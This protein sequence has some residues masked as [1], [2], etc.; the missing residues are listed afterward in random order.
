MSHPLNVAIIGLGGF[1]GAHHRTVRALELEGQCQ[2]ACVSSRS[3]P[4]D[5]TKDLD[6]EG[7]GVRL[8][9]DWK[10]MLDICGD[11]LDMVCVPTP[12]NMHAP[13]HRDCVD[14]GLPVFLEKPP[15]NDYAEL[16]SMLDVEQRAGKQTFVG[17]NF[18]CQKP[19]Q[20][21]K[22]RLLD[23]EFG[24]IKR[25][26]L[27]GLWPRPTSYYQRASWAGRL[28]VNGQ[29][30]LDS[31]FGNALAHHVFNMIFWHGRGELLSWG[32][33]VQVEAE[34]YR[35]HAIEGT[36]T[37]FVRAKMDDAGEL[38]IALTHACEGENI[39]SETIV[40]EKAK[41]VYTTGRGYEVHWIDGRVESG[42]EDSR[43]TMMQNWCTYLDYLRGQIDRPLI[44]LD[45]C[46]SYVH[47]YDLCYVAA[48]RI[49]S[50]GPPHL[51]RIDL[52]G[53]AGQNVVIHQI[54]EA[55]KQFL[56]DGAFPSAQGRAWAS[57]G[58]CATEQEL[59]RL[60]SVVERLA[61]IVH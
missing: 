15:T 42:D 19:R 20:E 43:G 34:L 33:V 10:Q 50:V 9:T 1:A 7:R 29:I 24:K 55:C 5:R 44:R 54:S 38:R 32:R 51:D 49:V 48:D 40:C 61:K 28:L 17:F 58:G 6:L 45:D 18:I 35:A 46:V 22:R 12:L 3:Q 16:A 26:E 23:G 4:L 47:L 52:E 30:V 8:F 27:L 41:I 2:L 39:H 31:C 60:R 59:P 13:M 21:L 57:P 14:R 11:E 56:K 53:E 25:T 37:T 36:D